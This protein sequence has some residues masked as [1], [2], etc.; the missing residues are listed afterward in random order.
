MS[1]LKDDYYSRNIDSIT[2]KIITNPDDYDH[3]YKGFFDYNL[4]PNFT[5]AREELEAY[6]RNDE[7]KTNKDT[8]SKLL[9]HALWDTVSR[10]IPKDIRDG[11]WNELLEQQISSNQWGGAFA[12][13]R[14]DSLPNILN[15]VT[16]GYQ[17]NKDK[18]FNQNFDNIP[19]YLIIRALYY[20]SRYQSNTKESMISYANMIR[21]IQLETCDI[22]ANKKNKEKLSP[23]AIPII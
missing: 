23:S 6:D 18:V 4:K 12:E 2:G 5:K 3:G 17:F 15:W 20:M 1:E 11:R 16:T 14:Y 7:L 9:Y 13:F 8:L 21:E 10:E 19:S 22:K